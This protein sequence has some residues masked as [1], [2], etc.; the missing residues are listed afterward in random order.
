M[1]DYLVARFGEYVLLKPPLTGGN[2]A[3]WLA[4]PALLILGGLVAFGF[5]RGRAAPAATP[6]ATLSDQEQ[7][8]LDALLKDTDT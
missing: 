3:L 1:R 5:L 4:A 7:A 2:L 8:R 6:P